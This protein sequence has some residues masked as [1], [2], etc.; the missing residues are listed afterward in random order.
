MTRGDVTALA[1]TAW[2]MS[3]WAL[4]MT[5]TS[6][7][8]GKRTFL[9]RIVWQWALK[10]A[11]DR[12]TDLESKISSSN[13]ATLPASTLNYIQRDDVLFQASSRAS[14]VK[15]I[16]TSVLSFNAG[17]ALSLI[18]MASTWSSWRV[19]LA[20]VALLVP[21]LLTIGLNLL[22]MGPG[23]QRWTTEVVT[24]TARRSYEALLVPFETSG[25]VPAGK[26]PFHSPHIPAVHA[27]EDLARA[28]EKYAVKR[29][30][31]DGTN[32]MT[33]VVRH[34]A[35]A[36]T[37]VRTLRDGVELDRTDDGRKQALSEVGR[38]LTVLAGPNLRDLVSVYGVDEN[39]LS[40]HRARTA[41]QRQTLAL[42]I[43]TLVLGGV[44]AALALS[45][46][47]LGVAVA[48]AA[49]TFVVATWAKNFGLSPTHSDTGASS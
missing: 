16:S 6:Q 42:T 13:L 4:M 41:W 24:A 20:G 30:L 48:T 15:I 19:P 46:S 5:A 39:L 10:R 22:A 34:Y 33:Q 14:A 43:F 44:V 32:P 11:A 25:R 1:I 45:T 8:R 36:A 40:E 3:L 35:A 37:H 21:V 49:A 23:M 7:R 18:V 31:P 26:E 29:A 9:E 28:L 2:T 12:R 27:L 38:L 17:G 47:G